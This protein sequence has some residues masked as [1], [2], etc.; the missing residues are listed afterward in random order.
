M[1]KNYFPYLVLLLVCLL[2]NTITASAQL[3]KGTVK[4]R[5]TDAAT[6]QPVELVS[7]SIVTV[8]DSAIVRSSVTDKTGVIEFTGLGTGNYRL[9]AYQLG[10]KPIKLPFS[11]NAITPYASL[12]DIVMEPSNINLKQVNINDERAAVTVKKDTVE[13]NAAAF[14]TQKNDNV[15]E[16]LKKI[17]GID[18]DKDGK[19]TSQG[20]DVNKVLVDGKEFFGNDPKAVTKN[21]PADAIA[22]VQVIDDK[23]DNAKKTGIDDGQRDKVINVTLKEDKKSGWFG[24]MSAAGGSE[25]RYLGQFN[26]NHFDKKKQVS[27]LSLSNNVNES[28]FTL[29]DLNNFAGGN[30]FSTFASTDGS[31]NVNVNSNGRA[32][33][34]GAFSGVSGGL[35]TTHTAG[36]NYTDE[37]G[38]DGKLKFNTNFVSILSKNTLNRSADL[39]DIPNNLFTTQLS[40]GNNSSNS[41]RFNM[42]FDYKIDSLNSVAFKPNASITFRKNY[43]SSASGTLNQLADSINSISQMLDQSTHSPAVGGQLSF[44]HRFHNGKGSVNFFT[45]GNYSANNA[46]YNNRSQAYYY[47]N[48]GLNS[49]INQQASQDNDAS[50]ITGTASFVRLLNRA[51][52]ITMNVSQSFD[53]RKQDANQYTVDYNA[54][55]GRYEILDPLYT[56]NSDN[57]NHRFTSTMGISKS[58]GLFNFGANMALAELGLHGISLSN[59]ILNDV[60]RDVWAFVPNGFFNYRKPNGPSFYFNIGT[61]VALPS[62]TDL[63]TVFNNTNPLYIRQG[64]P[65]LAQSRSMYVSTNYNF[66]DN[67]NNSYFNFYG[68]YSRTWNGFATTSTVDANGITTS[69][70]INVDGNYNMNLGFN[71]GRKTGIKGLKYSIGAYN[72][73]NRNINF[74]NGNRNEVTRFNPSLS[75]SSNYD[76]DKL[77]LGIRPYINYNIA[78]NSYQHTAD[79]HYYNLNGNFT[80]SVLP[81]KTWRVFSDLTETAYRG[82]QANLNTTFFL[83]NAG[84]EHYFLKDQNLTFSLNAFD[85]LDQNSGI[86]RSINTTGVIQNYQTNT[87]GQYFYLKLTYKI[88]KVGGKASNAS[89]SP[90]IIMR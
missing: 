48:S 70:P 33:I 53:I 62:A 81:S 90:I 13:F 73:L 63:Q 82:Q 51:K 67:K 75:F 64:N 20:K 1:A 9:L 42:A 25:D 11:I 50:F 7:V 40:N 89:G 52:K 84:I 65:N 6:K 86:Q 46:D 72:S 18:V 49:N 80:A 3:K 15:E 85:L 71:I 54:V 88:N 74:I 10:L 23:T 8:K 29:D 12:G 45:N 77:Q 59:N 16:L 30:A 60:N 37:F 79:Q 56:G 5:L 61:N 31:I 66:F 4:A 28:G 17:P 2:L 68:N 47:V 78:S 35:I 32:D 58:S 44:N 24:N 27:I 83:W 38:K 43:S 19:I 55:T 76:M 14:K 41:Y 39:Q 87:L 69:K 22:K 57:R 36:I 26:M 34:N 21:L